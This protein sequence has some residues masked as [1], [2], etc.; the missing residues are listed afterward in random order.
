M[1]VLIDMYF[2]FTFIISLRSLLY[3]SVNIQHCIGVQNILE[4][5]HAY[6]HCQRIQNWNVTN[7]NAPYIQN[8]QH[9]DQFIP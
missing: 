1:Y 6:I 3:I 7:S 4:L 2:C 8:Q 9:N 5:T